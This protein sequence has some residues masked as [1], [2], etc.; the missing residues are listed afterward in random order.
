[1][2]LIL[3][4]AHAG[5]VR[6][7][8]KVP[9]AWKARQEAAKLEAEK[10]VD[11]SLSPSDQIERLEEKMAKAIKEERYEDAAIIRDTIK[12]IQEKRNQT[13]G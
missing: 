7:V 10:K 2:H 3:K 4:N 11:E 5:G 9:K 12:T 8:G 13:S 1:M 6:H